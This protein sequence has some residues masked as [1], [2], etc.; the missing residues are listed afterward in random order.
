MAAALTLV[1]R[2]WP[3][4][5]FQYISGQRMTDG[6]M[7]VLDDAEAAVYSPNPWD[8]LGYQAAEEA[9]TLYDGGSQ[10]AAFHFLIEPIGNEAKLLCFKC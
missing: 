4:A 10:A 2:R 9:I 1:A 6:P 8:A 7:L 3:V 5:S